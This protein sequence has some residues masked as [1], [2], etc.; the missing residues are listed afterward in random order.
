MPRLPPPAPARRILGVDPGT[1]VA[2]WGVIEVTGNRARLVACGAVRTT[3]KDLPRRLLEVHG[4]LRDVVAAH[5]P[6]VL[7]VERPFFGKNASSAL[8]V[9]M[10]R[11]TAFLVAAE[12]GL[13]VREYPPATVKRAV[14]GNGN[15]SKEQVGRMVSLLLGLPSV[16]EPADATDALA[17][18]LADAHRA[19]LRGLDGSDSADE[20]G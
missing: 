10:A 16:P 20:V 1:R 12:A 17:V 13:A 18:A 3:A 14:V 4:A 8:A 7:A 6:G 2:G 19:A 9:G 5:R 15:A 11:G